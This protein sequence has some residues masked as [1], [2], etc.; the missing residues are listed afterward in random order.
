MT[1]TPL[2]SLL[3]LLGGAGVDLAPPVAFPLDHIASVL[4]TADLDGDGDVD[5]AVAASEDDL[6]ILLN[7]GDGTLQLGQS[8]L[9][10][11]GGQHLD[12]LARDLDGDGDPDLAVANLFAGSVSVL[13]GDGT[14]AFGAET[15]HDAPGVFAT[16]G[17]AAGDLDDDGDLD[18]LV[19]D[20]FT[21]GKT[22]LLNN[23]AAGFGETVAVS[24]GGTTISSAIG[25]LDG[26]GVLDAVTTFDDGTW[27]HA[28]VGDGS[29]EP[30][31]LLDPD[32]GAAVTL[33]DLDGDGDLDLVVAASSIAEGGEVRV[34]ANEAAGFVET[35]FPNEV[36]VRDADLADL[37]QDGDLDLVTG[38][39]A[40]VNEVRVLLNDGT[41][42]LAPAVGFFPG[43]Y[44]QSVSL[45]DLDGDG[46]VDVAT[47]NQFDDPPSVG[48]LVN[49]TSTGGACVSARNGSGINP[50]AYTTDDLPELGTTFTVQVD[51]GVLPAADGSVLL[52]A[53]APLEGA[54]TGAGELLVAPPIA[55]VTPLVPPDPG[56][57]STHT[58]P[59]PA[60]P[61]LEGL[62]VPTQAAVLG[63]GKQL[64]NAL[65]L[66]LGT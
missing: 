37:D 7:D 38:H 1:L 66:T 3:L 63:A 57:P 13:P 25:D 6:S 45:A 16:R 9:L 44:P 59:V 31:E 58:L 47:A 8:I 53:A 20:G 65:D 5:V 33:G 15:V 30:A 40:E 56:G 4:D 22:V 10:T 42:A 21:S 14:G 12:L 52:F 50:V 64:T 46:A 48:V 51:T 39:V 27:T 36:L 2:A 29:F 61:A 49:E 32:S 60:D 54:P 24:G 26:D 62:T 17:M 11:G 34:F 18:L 41:G 43:I 19:G 35:T 55:L 28:G 23:G